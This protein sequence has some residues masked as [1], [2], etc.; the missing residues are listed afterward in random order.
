MHAL[1]ADI[2]S[3]NCIG[4]L[5]W[6]LC[7]YVGAFVQRPPERTLS[8]NE[9]LSHLTSLEGKVCIEVPNRLTKLVRGGVMVHRKFQ[10]C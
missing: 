10:G 1:V 7:V 3:P 9:L 5:K 8:G 6:R 2:V 4:L